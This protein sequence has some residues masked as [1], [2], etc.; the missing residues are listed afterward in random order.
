MNSFDSHCDNTDIVAELKKSYLFKNIKA[1][2]FERL[3]A[4]LTPISLSKGETLFR[5]GDPSDAVYIITKGTL[6]AAIDQ[7]DGGEI[8]LGE[9]DV[10]DIV[11]EI[12]ILAIGGKRTASVSAISDTTL[13]K[14]PK[15]DFESLVDDFPAI[16]QKMAQVITRRLRRRQLLTILPNLFGPCDEATLQEIEAHIE[17][18]QLHSGEVLF[19]QEETGDGL[20]IVV[21]GRLQAVIDDDKGNEQIVGEITQGESVG[22]MAIFAGD[23][24][25]ATVYALRD[26]ELVKLSNTAFDKITQQNP[27]IMRAITQIIINRLRKGIRASSAR[28][29]AVNIAVIPISPKI[30]MTDFCHRLVAALS[31]FDSTLHLNGAQ[32]DNLMGMTGAAQ[33]SKKDPQSIRLVALLDEL[34]FQYR[35][36]K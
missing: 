13:I 10:G 1:G 7:A 28:S 18:I 3:S 9:I 21:S 5:Q 31:T 8:V 19:R 14:F 25:S 35:F 27:Q 34:E 4:H 17:W 12:H 23:K 36:I 16:L 30:A 29:N 2:I 32:L 24:R 20:Y 26:C 33:M 15:A 11:G 6:K 22:E